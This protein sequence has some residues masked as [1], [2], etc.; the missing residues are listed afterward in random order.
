MI[1]KLVVWG[2][3]RLS[4]LLKL[5]ACLAEFNIAGQTTNTIFTV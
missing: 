3:D 4:A 1:A 5:R 2:P